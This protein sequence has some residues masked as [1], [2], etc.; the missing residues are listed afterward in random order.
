MS[1]A[2]EIYCLNCG[3]PASP[4]RYQCGHCWSSLTESKSRRVTGIAFLLNEARRYPMREIVPEPE[5]THLTT[6]YRSA[7]EELSGWKA[8]AEAADRGKREATLERTTR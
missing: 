6:R 3:W 4:D 7:L 8:Q 5:L 1:E 2:D